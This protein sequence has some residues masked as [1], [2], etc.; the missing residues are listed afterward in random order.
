ML[1]GDRY[2]LL[3]VVGSGGMA[4]VW[5]VRDTRLD[6]VAALKRPHAASPGSSELARFRRESRL[7]ATVSH[8][9]LVAVFDAG[10][11]ETGP[12]LVMEYVDGPALDAASVPSERAAPLGMQVASGLAALH[13]VGIVHGDVKP[14]N[15]L[16]GPG[17]AKLTDFGIARTPDA[18]ATLTQP[19]VVLATPAYASPETL[20]RGERSPAA[21]VYS[22]GAVLYELVTGSRWTPSVSATRP[23]PTEP[24]WASVLGSA[25][26][27]EP[28][29]RPS[30]SDVADALSSMMSAGPGREVPGAAYLPTAATRVPPGAPTVRSEAYRP[31]VAEGQPTAATGPAD[32]PP[33]T[34]EPPRAQARA[35]GRRALAIFVAVLAVVG[36]VG[37]VVAFADRADAPTSDRAVPGVPTTSAAATTT[38][39]STSAAP[40]TTAPSS[41]VATTTVAPAVAATADPPGPARPVDEVRDELVALVEGLDGSE[42]RTNQARL[43]LARVGDAIDSAATGNVDK[44]VD[45]L[46]EAAD[47]VS[48]EVEPSVERDEALAL[49]AELADSLGVGVDATGDAG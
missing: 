34:I 1:V 36:A 41:S 18:T 22:L 45:R 33:G 14:A 39:P 15:I 28:S 9:H 11:D 27:L 29:G 2:E 6:R 43:I 8:P 42:L 4:T 46:T 47:R 23:A 30:A 38:T 32:R 3:D 24:A 25:L 49:I 17:G 5:R 21:D 40:S 7:A 13:D 10:E 16:L 37:L 35:T 12:Y 20:A 48:R 31:V 44:S 19:G 26:S